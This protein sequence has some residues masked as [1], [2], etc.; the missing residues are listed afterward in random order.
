MYE[1][2]AVDAEVVA[3]DGAWSAYVA[4]HITNQQG[5]TARRPPAA[6]PH[7]ADARRRQGPRA[8]LRR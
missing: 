6:A 1:D 7:V 2:A 3:A 8:S 4:E 5:S